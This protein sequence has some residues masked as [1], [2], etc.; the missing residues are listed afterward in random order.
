LSAH[1]QWASGL[2]RPL[3][4]AF[5]PLT[6][7]MFASSTHRVVRITAPNTV[8]TFASGFTETYD[9]DFDPF[10]CLYVDDFALG[11]LWQFCPARC[12]PG[13]EDRGS[14]EVEDERGGNGGDFE[15]EECD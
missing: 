8:M 6:G 7:N 2:E 11:E 4:V 9:L 15:F 1:T 3:N 13:E 10:G 14:G 5:E 12:K